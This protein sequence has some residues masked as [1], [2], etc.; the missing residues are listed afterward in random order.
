MTATV[1]VSG[2]TLRQTDQCIG[3]SR[4]VSVGCHELIPRAA[5]VVAL[6]ECCGTVTLYQS[7]TSPRFRGD[8][9]E[10]G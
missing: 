6:R 9:A 8:S 10:A 7:R 4:I 5:L 3:R 1:Y 2:F